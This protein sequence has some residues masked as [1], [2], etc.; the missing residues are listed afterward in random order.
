MDIKEQ[1]PF[2]FSKLPDAAIIVSLT[3]EEWENRINPVLFELGRRNDIRRSDISVHGRKICLIGND[4]LFLDFIHENIAASGEIGADSFFYAFGGLTDLS[5]LR[6][7]KE[8]PD[9]TSRSELE[10][11]WVA[12]CP[13]EKSFIFVN[14]PIP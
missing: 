8:Y 7:F 4:Q 13:D 12:E 14:V 9:E 3:S 1:F 5:I 2:L 10:N 6:R 11:P